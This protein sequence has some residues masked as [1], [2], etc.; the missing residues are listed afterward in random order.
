MH[1]MYDGAKAWADVANSDYELSE[2]WSE[3][4]RE[5]NMIGWAEIRKG[6]SIGSFVMSKNA[7][8]IL[9]QLVRELDAQDND[10]PTF[11]FHSARRNIL[12]DAI[13]RMTTEAKR[14]LGT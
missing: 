4:L 13:L 7:A 12:S 5:E 14:D 2:E 11:D 9:S 10:L 3:T 8:S 1:A 6:A